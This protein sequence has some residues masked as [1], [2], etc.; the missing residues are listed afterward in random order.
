MTPN[1]TSFSRFA[2]RGRALSNV[3]PVVL[4]MALSAAFLWQPLLTGQPMLP[5]DLIYRDDRIW[6]PLGDSLS[7][8]VAQN[9]VLSDV[10]AYYYPYAHYAMERLSDG[11]FPLWN[12]FI[13]TGTPFFASAQAAVLDPINL[14][15]YTTGPH[16]YWAWAAWLRLTMLGFTMFGFVRALGRSTQASLGAGI[17]FMLCGFVTVWLNYN[18]VTTLAWMP[19]L[20]WATARL[21]Q[22]GHSVWLAAVSLCIGGLFL[23]GHPETQF[24]VGLFW[25]AYCLYCLSTR[26]RVPSTELP[27]VTPSDRVLSARYLVPRLAAGGALGLGLGA[28]QLVPLVDFIFQTSS[29]VERSKPLIP[30]ELRN[31][32]QLLAVLFFPNF[33][34]NPLDGN[35]WYPLYTNFNE[36]TGYSGLLTIALAV[37]GACCWWRRDR[38]A[39]FFAVMGA[40]ALFFAVRA[41]G[42]QIP[43]LLPLFNVGH[44]VRWVII[45]SFCAAVLAAYGLDAL[46]NFRPR[47]RRLRDTGFWFASAALTSFGVLFL[48]YLGIKDGYWDRNWQVPVPHAEMARLFH[49]MS[50]TLYWPV[51]FLGGAALLLLAWWRGWVRPESVSALL[52]LFLYADLWSFGSLYNPVTPERAVYPSTEAIR[53]VQSNQGHGRVAGASGTLTPNIG[54]VFGLRDLRGYE[55][56]I[57]DSV[58]QLYRRNLAPI[59][60]IKDDLGL[61]FAGHRLLD[62]AG[63]RYIFM[64]HE[65]EIR[66]QKASYR[67]A[68]RTETT[69]VYE[70]RDALPRAYVVPSYRAAANDPAAIAALLSPS[71]DPRQSVVLTGADTAEQRGATHNVGMNGVSRAQIIWR[72]DEPE[73]IELDVTMPEAGYL[74]LSDYHTPEW[75][76]EAD[77]KAA[78]ILRANVAHRAVELTAGRHTVS[79]RYQPALFYAGAVASLTSAAVIVAIAAMH[80]LKQNRAGRRKADRHAQSLL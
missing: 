2:P 26:Y 11:Q 6:S 20:F 71:H 17:I 22:K 28:V 52:L 34:G 74:V 67:P 8:E 68:L 63:V 66:E 77:G 54:M 4:F 73:E 21:M 42:S 15:T 76:A 47:T 69:I 7:D 1:P 29:I 32:G 46:R 45:F 16:S 18:V 30:F 79:F 40:L 13:L 35:Y 41:P 23:G 48:F 49:P 19:A 33:S 44:G 62:I 14:L 25:G 5:T 75:I 59:D 31:T 24:L 65:V 37:L 60:P 27:A 70:N 51:L 72:K 78:P 39:P 53:Y 55:D 12:P 3:G 64:P 38:V 9:P 56:L 58:A 10:V 36:Q 43:K 80:L 57:G 50:L 61:D